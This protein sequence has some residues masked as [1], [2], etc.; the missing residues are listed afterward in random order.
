[1]MMDKEELKNLYKVNSRV[2]LA[3]LIGLGFVTIILL[4]AML[5][6]SRQQNSRPRTTANPKG[7][8]AQTGEDS[9]VGRLLAVVKEIDTENKRITLL[10]ADSRETVILDYTGGSNITDRYG[11]VIS[12]SQIDIASMVD[13]TYRR[14]KGLLTDMS[15]SANAWE[16]AGVSNFSINSG[17]KTMKIA[18]TKYR[19]NEDITILDGKDFIPIEKLTQQ[20]VLTVRGYEETIW[21]ITVTR[22]HGTVVLKDYEPFIGDFITIGYE[23]MQQITDGMEITVREGEFNLTVENGRYSAT[24]NVKINRNE[25]TV[26]SLADLGPDAPKHG[27]VKFEITPFGADLFIDR[28]LTSYANP[29]ELLYG[30]YNLK[31]TLGGYVTYEGV[32]NLDSAGKTIKIDLP[33]A[34]STEQATVTETDTITTAG[35]GNDN[36][37]TDADTDYADNDTDY[38]SEDTDIGSDADTGDDPSEEIR[39]PGHLVYIQSPLGASVYIDGE[40]MGT[41]PCSFEKIVGS[42]VLTLIEEGYETMSYAIEVENDG[43]DQYFSMPALIP[44]SR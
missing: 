2:I 12:I 38:T 43:K 26:V 10:D 5:S 32:L 19:Y 16:Y 34:K 14:D 41:S 9:S 40:Y 3:L 23:S 15:I 35:T 39:D 29:I 33:E 30:K 13:A 27:R 44:K 22:G 37:D 25:I 28:E 18:T 4:S 31:V 17:D 7:N 6:A 11:K 42:H 8:E 24:K 36:G 21:S 20:D 1:M